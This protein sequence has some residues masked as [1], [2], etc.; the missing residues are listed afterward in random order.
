MGIFKASSEFF[1]ED[2][3][4][5]TQKI[6]FGIIAGS[7]WIVSGL[8]LLFDA[9]IIDLV[10]SISG[11]IL[12][13]STIISSVESMI[14]PIYNVYVLSIHLTTFFIGIIGILSTIII[15][16]TLRSKTRLE[17]WKIMLETAILVLFATSLVNTILKLIYFNVSSSILPLISTITSLIAAILF[18]TVLPL[19]ELKAGMILIG[20][21]LAYLGLAVGIILL[22]LFLITELYKWIL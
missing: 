8:L 1:S 2:K 4:K 10:K 21:P 16:L 6:I 7:F 19:D 12:T 18:F 14:A 9:F 5:P 22:I 17:F 15:A 13:S 11:Q 3:E 20:V